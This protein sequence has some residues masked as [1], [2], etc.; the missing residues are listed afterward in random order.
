M[1]RVCILGAGS[2]GTAQSIVL[3]KNGYQVLM[4]VGPDSTIEYNIWAKHKGYY[5]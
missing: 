1:E 4:W 2:W 5:I 3:H